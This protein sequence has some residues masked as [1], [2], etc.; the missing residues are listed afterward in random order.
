[1]SKKKIQVFRQDQGLSKELYTPIEGTK[2][3]NEI[4]TEAYKFF[5]ASMF[6][7][8][9]FWVAGGLVLRNNGVVVK[10]GG[11]GNVPFPIFLEFKFMRRGYLNRDKNGKALPWVYDPKYKVAARNIDEMERGMAGI[12]RVLATVHNENISDFDPVKWFNAGNPLHVKATERFIADCLNLEHLSVMSRV[13]DNRANY[14]IYH[15]P[16][17]LLIQKAKPTEKV[18]LTV[19]QR[20]TADLKSFFTLPKYVCGHAILMTNTT[21]RR[22][23]GEKKSNII[24]K[25]YAAP[26]RTSKSP[27]TEFGKLNV[28][29]PRGALRYETS[30]DTEHVEFVRKWVN[31]HTDIVQAWIDKYNDPRNKCG[32]KIVSRKKKQPVV[33]VEETPSGEESGTESGEED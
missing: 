30:M 26:L 7:S 4:G 18:P 1:M 14:S 10:A 16:D 24:V 8:P 31:D 27:A 11:R 17:T 21:R 19:H 25:R 29:L 13:L 12:I 32:E 20:L 3:T 5:L 33:V 23:G 22:I 6:Y 9:T 2:Y 28:N 15:I